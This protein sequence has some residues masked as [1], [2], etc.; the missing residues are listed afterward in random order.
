MSA[1]LVGNT[2][3]GKRVPIVADQ[4]RESD[5]PDPDEKFERLREDGLV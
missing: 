3:N 4:G 2:P 1:H 5:H